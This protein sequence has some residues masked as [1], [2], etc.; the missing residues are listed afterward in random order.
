MTWGWVWGV[1]GVV[2]VLDLMH[3][4]SFRARRLHWGRRLTLFLL[5]Q[6]L[7]VR[8]CIALHPHNECNLVC[9]VNI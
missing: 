2:H 9:E 1:L 8:K 5:E 7:L 6:L 3:R 4:D